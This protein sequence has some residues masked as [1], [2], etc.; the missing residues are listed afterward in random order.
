MI[1]STNK[2]TAYII[3]ESDDVPYE[4]SYLVCITLTKNKA[5]ETVRYLQ[6]KNNEEYKKSEKL[7]KDY[8]KFEDYMLDNNLDFNYDETNDY[9]H[10][11]NI[12]KKIAKAFNVS[13]DYVKNVYENDFYINK[14]YYYVETTLIE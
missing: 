11:N 2:K 1:D 8:Y 7:R 14:N 9:E 10:D 6:K 5:E 13:Y 12:Y 4:S 3:Y